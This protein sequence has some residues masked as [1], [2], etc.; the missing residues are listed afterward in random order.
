MTCRQRFYSSAQIN[1]PQ[2][3]PNRTNKL[4]NDYA[5]SLP[6]SC[7]PHACMPYVRLCNVIVITLCIVVVLATF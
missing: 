3:S 2:M 6:M 7:F 1:T 5:P 4:I